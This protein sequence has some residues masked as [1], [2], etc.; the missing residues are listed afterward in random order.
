MPRL[1][2]RLVQTAIMAL[3]VATALQGETLDRIA[4]TVGKHVI[5]ESEVI[6]D[7]QAASLVMKKAVD[8]SPAAKRAAA[9][10]LVD[11][12]LILQ[13]AEDSHLS[14]LGPEAFPFVLKPIQSSYANE[15]EYQVDLKKHLITEEA[16]AS[17]LLSD[18]REEAFV[19]ARF[20]PEIQISEEDLHAYY[21]THFA[22]AS[23]AGGGRVPSF[24]EKR[25][26]MEKALTDQRATDALEKWLS[27]ARTAVRIEYRE[28]A[29][30]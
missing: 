8:L 11:Q 9:G 16:L 24:E 5:T 3:L 10:W 1:S 19:D 25:L 12:I 7:L 6:L 14:L 29:F 2:H 26:D 27:M 4:V 13:E 28:K 20:R 22:A 17:F 18:R 30:E 15:A 21:D 23:P